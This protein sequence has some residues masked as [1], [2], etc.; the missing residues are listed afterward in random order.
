ML[1]TALNRGPPLE[2][3]KFLK[4]SSSTNDLGVRDGTADEVPNLER[5]KFKTLTGVK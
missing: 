3:R 1:V 2:K 4:S 5:N